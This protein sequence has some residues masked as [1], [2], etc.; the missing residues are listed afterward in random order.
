M[1]AE[2]NS[3]IRPSFNW[4]KAEFGWAAKTRVGTAPGSVYHGRVYPIPDLAGWVALLVLDGLLIHASESV[5]RDLA[6]A[7]VASALTVATRLRGHA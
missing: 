2:L 4:E 5:S 7:S 6:K 3:V 1:V